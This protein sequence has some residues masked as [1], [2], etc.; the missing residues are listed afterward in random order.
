MPV[1]SVQIGKTYVSYHLM[2]IYGNTRLLDGVSKELKARLHGK[3]CFNFKNTD[4]ALI[5]ELDALT[6]Q[7]I[8]CFKK[9][10]YVTEPDRP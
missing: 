5:Q 1:A 3:T 6:A 7:A 10:G 9:S 8:L 2:G 4:D